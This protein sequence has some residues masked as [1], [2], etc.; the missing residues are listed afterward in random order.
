MT[1]LK[2]DLE[3]IIM[4]K[5]RVH[6]ELSVVGMEIVKERKPTDLQTRIHQIIDK[7]KKKKALESMMTNMEDPF[8]LINEPRTNSA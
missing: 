5:E 6:S 3:E 4:N 1:N 8:Y 7:K 2:V